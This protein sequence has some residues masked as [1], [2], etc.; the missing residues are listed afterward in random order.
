M[1]VIL[2]CKYTKE[3]NLIYE[4]QTCKKNVKLCAGPASSV[5]RPIPAVCSRSTKP[6]VTLE[7]SGSDAAADTFGAAALPGV[8]QG[9]YARGELSA[10]EEATVSDGNIP[11]RQPEAYH[12]E[13]EPE[14]YGVLAAYDAYS[15]TYHVEGDEYV[16]V[17]G[18]DGSTY[19]DEEGNLQEVDNTLMENPVSTF[20]RWRTGTSYINSA[21]DYMAM[22]NESVTVSGGD[23]LTVAAG[24]HMLTMAPTEGSFKDGVVKDNAI[25]YNNVLENVDYQYTVLGNSVKEDIILLDRQEQNRFSYYLNTYGLSAQVLHNTLYLYEEGKDPEKEAVFVLEAPEMED[26]AGEISFGVKLT[27]ENIST[28]NHPAA[29][30]PGDVLVTVTADKNW[31]DAKERV[32]PVRID[33]TAIQVPRSAIHLACAEE[34]SPNTVIG[35]NAYPYVGYDDGI[36]SGNL[37]GEVLY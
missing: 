29:N 28:G 3:R 33:P 8:T 24:D 35:D 14:N 12:E 11:L 1:V 15:R 17:I 6:L 22:L 2:H 23:L 20:A 37:A 25:R 26:A 10:L 13:P 9:V 27:V 16:T 34:G 36:T 5:G 21:N 32:Y 30:A 18:Y 19:L 4:N 31:L 7:V